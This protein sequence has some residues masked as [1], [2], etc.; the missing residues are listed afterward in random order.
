MEKREIEYLLI[1]DKVIQESV[2]NKPSAIG[3]F[4]GL[5]IDKGIETSYLPIEIL[6]LVRNAKG[7]TSAEVNIL[8]PN[9]D[10]ATGMKISGTNENNFLNIISRFANV[11][12]K[13]PGEYKITVTVNNERLDNDKYSFVIVKK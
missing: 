4:K 11:E 9:G 3:I 8:K 10:K 7:A 5:E 1:C 12:I 6:T 13:D 2:T